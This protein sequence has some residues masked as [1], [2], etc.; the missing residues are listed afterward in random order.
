MGEQQSPINIHNPIVAPELHERVTLN[1]VAGKQHFSPVK[2][3]DTYRFMP[4]AKNTL[5]LDTS[6]YQ[7]SNLHFHRPSEHWINGTRYDAELHAVH[8]KVDDG[9]HHCAVAIFLQLPDYPETQLG[10][11]PTTINLTELLPPQR[12][13]YRYEGSLTTPDYDENVSWIIMK[14]PIIL[15]DHHLAHFIVQ[16][17]DQAREPH[18]LHRRFVL[19]SE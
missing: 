11:P 15:P 14:N 9:I 3:G 2:L 5:Q 8:S 16:H 12:A 6:D 18:P 19:A 10:E 13:F 4:T 1:W 7:L 17:A